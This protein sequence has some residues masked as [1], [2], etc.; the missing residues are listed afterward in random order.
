[1]TRTL[2]RIGV[3]TAALLLSLTI[4]AGTAPTTGTRASGAKV[5][6][7]HARGARLEKTITRLPA[8]FEANAGQADARVKFLSR[9]AGHALMLTAEGATLA[10][11]TGGGRAEGARLASPLRARAESA[12]DA[13]DRA[14]S[15]R[16][17]GMKFVGANPR[18]EVVGEGR[19]KAKV[20]YFLG[21]DPSRWRADVP[22]FASVRYRGLYRGVD[23]VYY[24][25]GDGGRL[26]YDFV[27]APGADYRPI[28]LRFDGADR[29][30]IGAGGELLLH[31]KAGTIK[32]S[33]PVVY[34]EVGGARRE[35]AG[36]YVLRGPREV[37]FRVGEY[38]PAHA[39]V[40]DPVLVYSTYFPYAYEMAV[41]T[42]GGVY[43]TGTAETFAGDFPATPGAFQRTR[44]GGSDAY[45]A[46]LDAEGRE[47]VYLTYLGGGGA[48]LDGG[49]EYGQGVAVDA[50]GNAYVT[51]IT[52]SADFPVVNAFQPASGGG[53]SEGFVSKLNPDGSAL[54]YSSYLGGGET[55]WGKSVA[56]D[57]AGS[58]YVF[59][60]TFSNNFPVRNA[61]QPALKGGDDF[62]VTKVAPDGKTLDY[63][64]YLGGGGSEV[65]HLGDLAVDAAGAAYVA[66]T[67]YS[68]DYP[69]TPGAFQPATKTP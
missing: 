51:G 68:F 55:D 45:V 12:R 1:M 66:G 42:S 38:D 39:L 49:G 35:V 64:T 48:G 67:S 44:R 33:A 53:Y 21:R 6:A 25:G 60:Q 20:N 22:T 18:A 59:G 36:R 32:Q 43:V 17:V 2:T 9:G 37:G 8:R 40:I 27:L 11:R 7:A 58:A 14:S 23:L 5:S 47:L 15:F 10:L 56:L 69:V 4:L 61:L 3:L 19:L 34:Q 24:G 41:D 62:F 52:Y 46:K 16:L 13:R 31:T 54:V 65:G 63:S 30:T 26:E 28:R 50:A 57:A 29:L